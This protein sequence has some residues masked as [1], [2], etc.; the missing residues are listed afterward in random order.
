MESSVG[1]SVGAMKKNVESRVTVEG[2]A[3]QTHKEVKAL[4]GH[5]C[6]GSVESGQQELKKKLRLPS[7]QATEVNFALLP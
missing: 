6:E 1:D 5:S 3:V 4:L 2:W 7:D